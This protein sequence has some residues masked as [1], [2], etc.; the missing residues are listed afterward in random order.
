VIEAAATDA[1]AVALLRD[2]LGA[3]HAIDVRATGYSM[4]PRLADGVVVRVEPCPARALAAGDVVLFPRDDTLVLHRVLRVAR[5][6]VLL[7]GDACAGTDGW[8]PRDH[9]LGRLRRRTGDRTMARLAPHLG[10]AIGLASAIA[11]HTHGFAS[12]F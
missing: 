4:W 5:S 12:K 3:G 7:K 2:R 10:P 11:R 9:I 6:R 8:V 1:V